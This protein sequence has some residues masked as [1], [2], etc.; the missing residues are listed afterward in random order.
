MNEKSETIEIKS[1]KKRKDPNDKISKRL[2]NMSDEQRNANQLFISE[3]DF[4]TKDVLINKTINN[5]PSKEIFTPISLD[6]S[7][8]MEKISAVKPNFDAFDREVCFACISEQ[9][10]GHRFTTLNAIYRNITGDTKC[11]RPKEAMYQRIKASISKLTFSEI[12]IDLSEVCVRYGLRKEGSIV[13][14]H[15]SIIP[16]KYTETKIKGQ[17]SI[18]VEFYE[19]SPLFLAAEIKNGQILTYDKKLLDVPIQNSP[20]II[21]IKSYVLRRVLEIIAH[22]MTPT[23]T[24]ADVFEKNQLAQSSATQKKRYRDYM[25]KMFDF[26]IEQKLISSYEIEKEGHIPISINFTYTDYRRRKIKTIA[27]K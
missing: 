26:W 10:A 5:P 13:I 1:L 12:T 21:V 27:D 25:L 20:E 4:R 24:F 22:K 8:Y 3:G 9:V 2:F 14:L 17:R 19:P 18:L 16:G 11:K 7:Q 23:I 6:Y 15:T